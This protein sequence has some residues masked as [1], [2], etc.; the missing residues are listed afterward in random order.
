MRYWQIVLAIVATT[1]N[2]TYRTPIVF[3]PIFASYTA[4][5]T[6]FK[7][8]SELRDLVAG[9]FAPR[10]CQKQSLSSQRSCR[11]ARGLRSDPPWAVVSEALRTLGFKFACPAC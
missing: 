10:L 6:D 11:L 8:E 1:W 3:G 9:T 5:F 2:F 4:T 7:M